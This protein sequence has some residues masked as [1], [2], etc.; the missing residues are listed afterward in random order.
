M[1]FL[2]KNFFKFYFFL[3]LLAC[4]YIFSSTLK[5][6]KISSIY[7]DDYDLEY[8]LRILT[9]TAVRSG[10]LPLWDHWTHGGLPF[11]TLFFS[12]SFSP[13]ILLLSLFGI[14]TLKTFILEILIIY[15]LGFTGMFFWLKTYVD[16]Y[17][18]LLGA[19]CFSLASFFI[20]EVPINIEVVISAF[21][22][23]WLAYGFKKAFQAKRQAILIITFSLWIMFSSGYLG[24]NVIAMQFIFIFCLIEHLLNKFNIRGLIY[25]LIGILLFLMI[26][27]FPILE[28]YSYFHFDFSQIRESTF[29]PY[30]AAMKLDTF[31][32]AI[33]PNF[34]H[35]SNLDKYDS[36]TGSIF[37]GSIN[38]IYILSAIFLL[39]KNKIVLLLYIFMFISLFSMLSKEFFLGRFFTNV[40]PFYNKVRFHAFNIGIFNFF[41]LT[42]SSIGL[43]N[44]IKKQENSKKIFSILAYFLLALLFA[45]LQSK[46]TYILNYFYYPQV[47]SFIAFVMLFL[48][49]LFF[50]NKNYQYTNSLI[51]IVI[52]LIT[53]GEFSLLSPQ[54]VF[55]EQNVL[56][57][58]ELITKQENLKTQ[59]FDSTTNER[60][61]SPS[62]SNDQLYSKIPSA[63][64][65]FPLIH[66]VIKKLQL[67]DKY[68]ELMKNIF[69]SS[70]K[71]GLPLNG[72]STDI[73]IIKFQPNYVSLSIK[74]Q[75]NKA[76]IVWS[77]PYTK[78]WKIYIN[79][80]ISQ[81]NINS[82]GLTTFILNK[83]VNNIELKYEPWYLKA[84]FFI[85]LIGILISIY[86]LFDKKIKRF[87]VFLF[88]K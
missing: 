55:L 23:P 53:L 11:N 47:L 79:K 43:V 15:I 87:F 75:Q 28:T 85:S 25:T 31:F 17:I 52:T 67:S 34:I 41:A 59:G 5:L 18:S 9:S 63:F 33:W 64:G 80:N 72:N 83:N 78:N 56:T 37:F 39:K 14:Y 36:V 26:I 8:P 45:F 81:T 44:F 2:K 62:Y 22:Y 57:H 29:D 46:N 7:W 60:T 74:T 65:Y 51:I 48:L 70:D 27:N 10:F 20:L 58:Q 19:A 21:M 13:V 69:Y 71:E 76:Q 49:V 32:T 12:T 1:Q 16:K 4:L 84:S 77:S 88:R 24:V 30:L 66:P 6:D 50:F 73:K 54:L 82:F 68:L 35:G 3:I 38:L 42:L 40:I 61:F 86:L